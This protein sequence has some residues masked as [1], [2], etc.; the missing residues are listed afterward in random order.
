MEYIMNLAMNFTSISVLVLILLN[1][2]QYHYNI[3]R[4]KGR[5]NQLF[6]TMIVTNMGLLLLDS[7]TW[8]LN[9]IDTPGARFWHGLTWPPTTPCRA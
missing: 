6:I 9:G 5:N 1:F 8:I 2:G 4:S 3:R 7:V